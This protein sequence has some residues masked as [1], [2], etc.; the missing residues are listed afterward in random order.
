MS[1]ITINLN[2]RSFTLECNPDS[3]N[4][5]HELASKLDAEI[6]NVMDANGHISFD[7]ALVMVSLKLL[8]FKQSE[9]KISGGKALEDLN[10][11]FQNNMADISNDLGSLINKLNNS[12][13]EV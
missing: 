7:M 9:T 1:A 8:A 5:L 3:H 12:N 6:K 11:E 13:I 10:K 4:Q 2:S